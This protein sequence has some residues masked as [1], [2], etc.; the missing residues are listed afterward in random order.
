MLPDVVTVPVPLTVPDPNSTLPPVM[1]PDVV[2][3]PVPALTLPA[4]IVPVPLTVPVPKS[5]LPPEMLLLA[6]MLPPTLKILVAES[7][8]KFAVAPKSLLLLN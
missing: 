6:V 8:V 4:L 3:I 7:N 1:L 2:I 5:M